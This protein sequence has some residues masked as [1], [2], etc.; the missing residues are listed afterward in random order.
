MASI[1]AH[2]RPIYSEISR[3]SID[4][5]LNSLIAR[6]IARRMAEELTRLI[7]GSPP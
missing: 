7:D 5:E 3:P 6:L 4:P 1:R 2:L